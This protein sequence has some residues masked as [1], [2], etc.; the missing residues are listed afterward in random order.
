MSTV[1]LVAVLITAM[2]LYL[3]ERYT[4]SAHMCS[5]SSGILFFFTSVVTK[6]FGTPFIANTAPSFDG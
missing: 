2:P 3:S 5:R 4:N 6:M 1:Q